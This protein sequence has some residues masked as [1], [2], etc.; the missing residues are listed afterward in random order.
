[1][2]DTVKDTDLVHFL[3]LTLCL[4]TFVL[5]LL[6]IL[7]GI[8]THCYQLAVPKCAFPVDF[9]I[10]S[11]TFMDVGQSFLNC[12]LQISGSFK[13]SQGLLWGMG[14]M[15]GKDVLHPV[16][17]SLRWSRLQPEQVCYSWFRILDFQVRF[18]LN[19]GFL[20]EN[21]FAND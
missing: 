5:I 16:W 1:M 11:S 2:I 18:Y 13:E 20:G 8:L 9:C 12:V 19:K 7:L 4:M 14:T 15:R 6:L 21:K 17:G 3:E 10:K